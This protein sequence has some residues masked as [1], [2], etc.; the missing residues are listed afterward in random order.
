MYTPSIAPMG[1]RSG[2]ADAVGMSEQEA[3]TI[4]AVCNII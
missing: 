4:R 1:G 2:A 3:T